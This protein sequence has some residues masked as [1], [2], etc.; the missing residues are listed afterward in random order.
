MLR[1]DLLYNALPGRADA[2]ESSE[3]QGQKGCGVDEEETENKVCESE[4]AEINDSGLPR[5]TDIFK[6]AGAPVDDDPFTRATA[7]PITSYES[8]A[9]CAKA[10][11]ERG[12]GLPDAEG[13][14]RLDSERR[15]RV[16]SEG[17]GDPDESNVK[18]VLQGT[19][20]ILERELWLKQR[21][22][23]EGPAGAGAPDPDGDGGDTD[24]YNVAGGQ[25]GQRQGQCQ[26][27]SSAV[28]AASASAPVRE[29]AVLSLTK[30]DPAVLTGGAR[31]SLPTS[32]SS[33]SSSPPSPS[34]HS[35]SRLPGPNADSAGCD[36]NGEV[37]KAGPPPTPPPPPPPQTTAATG[38]TTKPAPREEKCSSSSA[39][40][41]AYESLA[42]HGDRDGHE[43]QRLI[44][45]KGSANG[46][47][48]N[49]VNED[50]E[51]EEKEVEEELGFVDD[52]SAV[53][54]V[55]VVNGHAEAA[56]DC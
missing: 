2:D 53:A 15:G 55:V 41:S 7:P 10:Q 32:S 18:E 20:D 8:R 33:S 29:E 5:Y 44:R 43:Y 21:R 49:V 51:E 9:A 34:S 36:V 38:A 23:S 45:R 22:E 17:R 52:E 50:L 31:T 1:S 40:A 56:A 30:D 35:P 16:E 28:V 39:S 12:R 42:Q 46:T 26:G 4:Y 37:G 25:Q 48:A 54:A 19:A 14:G 3:L 47:E 27:Q 13:R 6:E 24:Y 11:C